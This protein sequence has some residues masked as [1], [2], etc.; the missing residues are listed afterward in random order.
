[1]SA[2]PQET[3]ADAIDR[4][5]SPVTLLKNSQAPLHTFVG[6]PAEYTNWRSEQRVWLER[7]ALIDQSHHMSDLFLRGPDA[8]K[9]LSDLGVNSFANFGVNKAKQF[10]AVDPDGRVIG[11]SILF[12][13]EDDLFDLVGHQVQDWVRFNLERRNYDATA[14]LDDN[15]AVRRSGPP[16]FYRFE[17]QGPT[18]TAV[19]AEATG[20]P[21]PDARFFSMVE[22]TIAGHR[23]RG[24]RHGMAGQPGFELFGPWE[25]GD[26]VLAALL[27][28]GK[29]HG[30][31]RTGAKAYSTINLESGWI[32]IPPPAIY[33]SHPLMEEYRQWLP[34][35]RTGS[36][37]GSL[38]A[39]SMADYNLTPYELG[40]GRHVKFDHDFVGREALERIADG[41][42][43]QKVTLVW[44]EDDVADTFKTMFQPGPGAKFIDMP[45]GRYALHHVDEVLASDGSP[46]GISLDCGY[47]ANQRAMVSLAVLDPAYCTTGT[48]VTV[49]WGESPNSTK[50]AVEEHRQVSIRATVAPVPYAA[51][52]RDR[53]R[54]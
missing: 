34:A 28:A 20:Q 13:L 16:K 19:I 52:A 44:N 36:L 8:M 35:S 10:V 42:H 18:A 31:E 17:L 38:E 14:E 12:H 11:D 4:V 21:V 2:T 22:F 54:S 30:L 47:I 1:M 53:Y 41:P 40:Y 50:P 29:G 23:V 5:G 9:L 33:S 49:V 45:K 6:V 7:C 27:E 25:Q 43:R 3:L 48:E 51:F 39:D 24:L 46:A 15:S 32:P 37:S 26:D